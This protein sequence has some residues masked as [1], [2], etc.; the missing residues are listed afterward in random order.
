[1]HFKGFTK[2]VGVGG[3]AGFPKHI[4]TLIDRSCSFTSHL[5]KMLFDYTLDASINPLRQVCSNGADQDSPIAND[6]GSDYVI[7]NWP[8]FLHASPSIIDTALT[9]PITINLYLAPDAVLITNQ[10]ADSASYSLSDIMFV[11]DAI[12][13]DDGVYDQI[14]AKRLQS[15]PIPITFPHF[16]SFLGSKTTS[17]STGMTFGVSSQSVDRHVPHSLS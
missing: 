12:S 8:G 17:M 9:G 10:S 14:V 7:M 13:L 4:E 11:I 1:M 5:I 2:A 15:G 6:E 16:Q 3:F